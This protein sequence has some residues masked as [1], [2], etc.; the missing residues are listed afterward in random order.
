M[1][2]AE[3]WPDDVEPVWYRIDLDQVAALVDDY[4]CQLWKDSPWYHE[5][6][7]PRVTGVLDEVLQR[8]C[9]DGVLDV[10]PEQLL[11]PVVPT[12]RET[13]REG[14]YALIWWPIGI[15]RKELHDG[16]HRAAAMR[17]QGVRFVP[18][19]CLRGDVGPGVDADQLYPVQ[20]ASRGGRFSSENPQ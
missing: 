3:L 18:G 7:W 8:H 4:A 15:S 14:L 19:Q 16:G 6:Q 17:A 11:R 1:S 9:R 12:L 5:V 10:A 13:D 20:E 2:N